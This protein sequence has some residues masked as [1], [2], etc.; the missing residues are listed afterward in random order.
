MAECGKSNNCG[1]L[2]LIVHKDGT[3]EVVGELADRIDDLFPNLEVRAVEGGVE[4]LNFYSNSGNPMWWDNGWVGDDVEFITDGVIVADGVLTISPSKE[5]QRSVWRIGGGSGVN[6]AAF[7]MNELK[8]ENSATLCDDILAYKHRDSVYHDVTELRIIAEQRYIDDIVEACERG[9]LDCSRIAAYSFGLT[10]TGSPTSEFINSVKSQILD[11]Y[12]IAVNLDHDDFRTVTG[13]TVS[14]TGGNNVSVRLS[15]KKFSQAAKDDFC[16]LFTELFDGIDGNKTLVLDDYHLYQQWGE[17]ISSPT[18]LLESLLSTLLKML[19]CGLD[20][21]DVKISTILGTYHPDTNTFDYNSLFYHEETSEEKP[22]GCAYIQYMNDE[23]AEIADI[24]FEYSAGVVATLAQLVG[25]MSWDGE[26]QC[27]AKHTVMAAASTISTESLTVTN[28]NKLYG[29]SM[30]DSDNSITWRPVFLIGTPPFP[31][32]VV[33]YIDFLAGKHDVSVD[34]IS[35]IDNVDPDESPYQFDAAYYVSLY[36]ASNSDTGQY[37]IP[38]EDKTKRKHFTVFNGLFKPDNMGDIDFQGATINMYS[39]FYASETKD[40]ISD[41]LE[42]IDRGAGRVT[43]KDKEGYPFVITA[44]TFESDNPKYNTLF[45][46][47]YTQFSTPQINVTTELVKLKSVEGAADAARIAA[48]LG[49]PIDIT[50]MPVSCIFT[51]PSNLQYLVADS[52]L[53]DELID[54]VY[55][56]GYSI[57]KAGELEGHIS[58]VETYYGFDIK[59]DGEVIVT[60]ARGVSYMSNSPIA[61]M[62][63]SYLS[64]L[65]SIASSITG[66]KNNDDFRKVVELSP[67][68][69]NGESIKLN[70]SLSRTSTGTQEHGDHDDTLYKV[71]VDGFSYSEANAPTVDEC[72]SDIVTLA[73]VSVNNFSYSIQ[74]SNTDYSSTKGKVVRC[75]PDDGKISS[76][77]TTEAPEPLELDPDGIIVTYTVSGGGEDDIIVTYKALDKDGNDVTDYFK[78][79]TVGDKFMHKDL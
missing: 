70:A 36:G 76:S 48:E 79:L 45:E 13:H 64:V 68:I 34:H 10:V 22:E 37:L 47:K 27:E 32:G 39:S 18:E 4:I 49:V 72:S 25:G 23:E 66:G 28:L 29:V 46:G 65:D 35:K 41:A 56:M 75:C 42:F 62:K 1:K 14:Y 16:T 63:D 40:D 9:L 30:D 61:S 5:F 74:V 12:G 15:P 6:K 21:S 7:A 69:S 67:N 77:Q 71:T 44:D 58:G 57:D 8:E 31:V 78:T 33:A 51:M 20:M 26:G 73:E 60:H 59:N 52:Q 2:Q 24:R 54:A 11:Q 50:S 19:S 17:A 55:S 38:V 53:G 43:G 3:Y